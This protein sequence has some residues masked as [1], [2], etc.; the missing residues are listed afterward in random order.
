MSEISDF[1]DLDDEML[2]ELD[3]FDGVDCFSNKEI[4]S[5]NRMSLVEED[6]EPAM[7]KRKSRREKGESRFEPIANFESKEIKV[8]RSPPGNSAAPV[9]PMKA[10]KNEKPSDRRKSSTNYVC[11]VCKKC[12]Q[13]LG[14]LRSHYLL[15]TGRSSL[16]ET[17]VAESY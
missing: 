12:F 13:Q 15:H 8:E 14:H 10:P 9:P 7:K 17:F 6:N 1:L 5:V 11:D 2:G 3:F 16:H 4:K